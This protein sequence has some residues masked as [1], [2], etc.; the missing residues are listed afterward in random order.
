MGQTPRRRGWKMV[1]LFLHAFE[2]ACIV[3]GLPSPLR[4]LNSTSSSFHYY[5][6]FF[7]PPPLCHYYLSLFFCGFSLLALR[8]L[9]PLLL[10]FFS[11]ADRQQKRTHLLPDVL[12]FFW[13]LLLFFFF[14]LFCIP[15]TF[16]PPSFLPSSVIVVVEIAPSHC[17]CSPSAIFLVFCLVLSR[18]KWV[19]TSTLFFVVVVV[20]L[21][22]FLSL[23]L[24]AYSARQRKLQCLVWG[25]QEKQTR[26]KTRLCGILFD[27]KKKKETD[28]VR[29]YEKQKLF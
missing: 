22:L 2:C 18:R 1:C 19:F 14:L 23:T 3:N 9:P 29:R 10:F 11:D 24:F 13:S 7:S 8:L 16:F 15:W 5:Y 17:W 20:L 28:E 4:V 12:F 26:G 27:K 6:C 21:S 25:E